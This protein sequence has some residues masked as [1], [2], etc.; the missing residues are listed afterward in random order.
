MPVSDCKRLRNSI[1]NN[2]SLDNGTLEI[3]QDSC[4]KSPA[5]H[6]VVATSLPEGLTSSNTYQR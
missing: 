2:L 3:K 6:E 4:H 1:G 5:A